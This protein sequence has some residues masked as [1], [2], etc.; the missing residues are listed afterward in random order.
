MSTPVLSDHFMKRKPSGIRVA[1]LEFDQRNDGTKAVNVA[2]GDVSLPMHP[3]MMERLQNLSVDY[4][5]F[6]EGK[7]RY[8]S[9][10]G[11]AETNEAFFNIL[12][13]SGFE[14]KGLYSQVTSGGAEAMEFAI[15]GTCASDRPLLV[16]EPI[17]P[18]YIEFAKRVR[19]PV[20]S[21]RRILQDDGVF[22][23]PHLQEIEDVIRKTNPGAVVVIPFDNPSGQLI[24]KKI[25]SRIA[26][27]CVKYNIWYVC[28]EAYRE[29]YYV[30][31]E[32]SSIWGIT[33]K[34]VPGIE[35]RRI[36]IESTSKVW[37]ACG[38]RIGALITDNKEFHVKAVAE[39]TANL[40]A[41]V[42]GQYIFG[43]V[44]NLF[45]DELRAWFKK[46]REYYKPMFTEFTE[47][48]KA[49]LPGIIVSNPEASIYSVIDVRNIAF[50][51]FDALE[52]VMY[53]AREGKV[54][55]NG[56][57][58][59]LLV[60]PM[61]GFYMVGSHE[62]N[63]GKTQMRVSYVESPETMRVVPSLFADLMKQYERNRA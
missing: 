5:P 29:L 27:L 58:Y 15:L 34:D 59:T 12:A 7:I 19:V 36:S 25:M 37:N 18:N 9:S 6:K 44:A 16:I 35:G 11:L 32:L 1:Q 51:R 38:L 31:S 2:I 17:Y 3:A 41:N 43:A 22:S 60:A 8:S 28:D 48:M 46:Q 49:K 30:D 14:T 26:E 33:D 61:S 42:L 24:S 53:C 13:A 39:A 47:G 54:K 56:E 55:A 23:Y 50:A 21:V 62:K 4:S 63:P 10:K 57:D 40:C 45:G 20:V 52:F